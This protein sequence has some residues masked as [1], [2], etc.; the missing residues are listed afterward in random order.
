MKP[1]V[2][3]ANDDGYFSRSLKVLVEKFRKEYEV[4]V[5]A[6][7]LNRSGVGRAVSLEMPIKVREIEQNFYAVSGTPVDC[8]CF[9]LGAALWKAPSLVVT[10]INIGANLGT[11]V[12]TS[13]TVCAAME[14][15]M[16]GI[17][18]IAVSQDSEGTYERTADLALDVAKRVIGKPPV[19]L[20]INTPSDHF[21]E[22]R[23][24]KLGKRIYDYRVN[25]SV[26][27][28]GKAY[29]WIGGG[30]IVAVPGVDTD[31]QA[32]LDGAATI[33]PLQVDITE[34]EMLGDLMDKEK[35]VYDFGINESDD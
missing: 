8:M 28:R 16:R 30:K 29:Y 12:L 14:G 7:D 32:I 13:G 35:G 17:P 33:T 18:S 31:C 1:L 9:G 24:T 23:W 20:N 21:K 5:V 19:L 34:Y 26:D 10:G 22:V 15:Y 6:P 25:K 27:P 3:I 2:L 11:D 4:V